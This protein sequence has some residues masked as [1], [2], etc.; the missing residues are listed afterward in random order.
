[1]KRFNEQ[2]F[3]ES[4]EVDN[5]ENNEKEIGTDKGFFWNKD[6]VETLPEVQEKL[7]ELGIENVDLNGTKEI[8]QS[9]ITK[10]VESMLDAHPEIQGCIS[11]IRTSKLRDGVYACAGPRMTENGLTT[12]ILLNEKM[13]SKSNLELKIIDMETDNFKGERWFAGKGLDGVIKHEMAHIMH[14][15]MIAENENIEFGDKSKEKFDLLSEKFYRNAIVVSMCN[16]S[17]K[18]LGISP[19]DIG[20]ELSVYGASDFGEFFA[21]AISECETSKR[22]RRLAKRVYEKYNEYILKKEMEL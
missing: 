6:T 20:K 2:D 7:H 17:I 16:D 5:F 15:K 14:L 19:R 8:W 4:L 13:F 3:G 10:S 18:E 11:G 22:P 9:K 1:M 21:E 12:E